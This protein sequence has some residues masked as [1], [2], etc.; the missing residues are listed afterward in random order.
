[1]SKLPSTAVS[2]GQ[3]SP[4]LGKAAP[5]VDLVPLTDSDCSLTAIDQ[6]E[7]GKVTLLHF[8]GT[9]CGPCRMGY[10]D[11]ADMANEHMSSDRFQFIPVSCEQHEGESFDNLKQQTVDYFEAAQ[12]RSFAYCDPRSV[13]RLSVAKRL[14]SD[15]MFFPTTVL[16]ASDG[17]IA[18]V[19][20]G[21]SKGGVTEMHNA[22]TDL[23]NR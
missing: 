12:V 1:M 3:V 22:I 21:F 14:E 2:L 9:W 20:E 18:G 17:S 16:I 7:L 23:L 15:S 5:E 8:W 19:W 10:P 11:L 4:A 13:T 6:V